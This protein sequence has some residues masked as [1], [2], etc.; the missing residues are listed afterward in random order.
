M[1][2]DP[3][4]PRTSLLPALLALAAAIALIL[5]IAAGTQL[6]FVRLNAL[7]DARAQARELRLDIARTLSLVKDVE[8]GAR[9]YALSG[10]EE[11]LEPYRWAVRE[12]P[13]AYAALKRAVQRQALPFSGWTSLD[14]LMERRLDSA[15]QLVVRRHTRGV[16]ALQTLDALHEG[17]QAMEE[18][19]AGFARLDLLQAAHIDEQDARLRALRSRALILTWT[20]TGTSTL[21]ML[22]C[23]GLML[24]ERR[25]RIRLAGALQD[26]NRTLEVRVTERTRALAE[27][28]DRIGDYA[29]RLERSVEDERRRMAREVHDQIGQVFTGLRMILR[30]VPAGALAP[31]QERL[32]QQALDGGIATARRIASE[33]RPPLLD[34]L[35]LQAALQHMLNGLLAGAALQVRVTLTD[36]D[37]LDDRQAIGLFRIV[38]EAASNVLHHAQASRFGVEGGR[39]AAGWRLLISDDGGGF[40]P[41]RVR[42]GALGLGGMRERAEL[43]GAHLEIDSAPGLDTRLTLK[44]PLPDTAAQERA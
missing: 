32:M 7:T 23:T 22:A 2:P 11:Y 17:R 33:L 24:H 28:R 10:R 15:R 30:G 40:D 38:Q 27:A 6:S 4:H 41:A 9:G 19:R 26:A 21:L 31:E 20:A 18:L 34:D 8:T 37:R 36:T 42:R 35:G 14:T 44:L 43:L 25:A 1:P 16:E 5:A 29:V 3:H 39:A 13:A 12:L